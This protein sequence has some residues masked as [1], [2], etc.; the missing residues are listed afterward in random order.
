MAVAPSQAFFLR[1]DS[2]VQITFSG[3]LYGA[4]FVEESAGIVQVGLSV[5]NA[6]LGP[7]VATSSVLNVPRARLASADD[8]VPISVTY[9]LPLPKGSFLA[10]I[11]L[12]SDVD[13]A[14]ML[15]GA[16]SVFSTKY[17]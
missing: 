9:A 2:V 17:A 16:L 4:A 13:M 10:T 3:T 1:C 11:T 14:V 7:G 5:S 15:D 12:Q 8:V 6:A